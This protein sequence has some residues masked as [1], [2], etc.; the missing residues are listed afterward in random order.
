MRTLLSTLAAAAATA[1]L[2]FTLLAQDAPKGA[3]KAKGPPKNLKILK[4]DNFRPLMDVFVASLG[5]SDKGGC[6]Y[7]HVADRSSDENPKK[8]VARMMLTMVGEINAKFPDGKTHVACFTCH[9]GDPIPKI[10]P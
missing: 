3:P 4:A 6:N 9:R 8:D 10:E 7:C 5:L 2:A 1:L